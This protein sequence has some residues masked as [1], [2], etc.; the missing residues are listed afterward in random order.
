[1]TDKKTKLNNWEWT[2]YLLSILST[3]THTNVSTHKKYVE[4]THCAIWRMSTTLSRRWGNG[5]LEVQNSV[6]K[7]IAKWASFKIKFLYIF[8]RFNLFQCQLFL[9]QWQ[10]F[11]NWKNILQFSFVANVGM[12]C[13]YCITENVKLFFETNHIPSHLVSGKHDI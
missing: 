3:V 2:Y 10:V 5:S 7:M 13:E 4:K 9:C 8:Q 11:C 12:K 1:M 6:C